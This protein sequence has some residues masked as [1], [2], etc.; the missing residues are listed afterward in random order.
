MVD[1]L[2]W[3]R[4]PPNRPSQKVPSSVPRPGQPLI[5]F[6]RPQPRAAQPNIFQNV[7]ERV[8]QQQQ[9]PNVF[10][11]VADTI[12]PRPAPTGTPSGGAPSFIRNLDPRIAN[13]IDTA[14]NLRRGLTGSVPSPTG[15]LP[16][17]RQS[18]APAGTAFNE[19]ARRARDARERGRTPADQRF[20]NLSNQQLDVLSNPAGGDDLTAPPTSPG[21]ERLGLTGS[22]E[23]D[24]SWLELV[25]VDFAEDAWNNPYLAVKTVLQANGIREDS[26]L[27]Q[28]MLQ[29]STS[30]VDWYEAQAAEAT[31]DLA[32]DGTD[33]LPYVQ[34]VLS[35]YAGSVNDPQTAAFRDDLQ[36]RTTQ[37]IFQTFADPTAT[38]IGQ[39]ILAQVE[40]PYNDQDPRTETAA[41]V[42]WYGLMEPALR[43][44][45]SNVQQGTQGRLN[46]AYEDYLMAVNL[47]TFN[48]D[49]INYVRDETDLL[50]V[51]Q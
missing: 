39:T 47:G 14:L 41:D 33:F 1:I 12:Q 25:P 7:L 32:A 28:R 51:F 16:N 17:I 31:G 4:L 34:G 22:R 15:T 29:E 40:D 24:D 23:L 13:A 35:Y 42:L 37:N 6:S 44:R 46:K 11:R 3:R 50:S 36:Q 21:A 26:D 8:Q 9:S 45:S 18:D 20:S 30:Y 5:D 38:E 10:Q 48:G 2:D 19:F 49:F 43:N 27:G